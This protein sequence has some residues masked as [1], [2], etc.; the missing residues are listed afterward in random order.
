MGRWKVIMNKLFGSL[1]FFSQLLNSLSLLPFSRLVDIGSNE[2]MLILI[3][4]FV[5]CFNR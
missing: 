5:S 3:V 1:R 4:E 2:E